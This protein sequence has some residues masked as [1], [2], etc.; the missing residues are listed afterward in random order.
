MALM[1][2]LSLSSDEEN[3]IADTSHDA[4][5]ARKL[6]CD[7]N[8]DIL[9]PP[10]DGKVIVLNDS[11]EEDEAQEEKTT[12]TEP[13]ATSIVVKSASTTSAD[14]DNAPTGAKNDNSD[15]QEPDQEA[16]GNDSGSG[17]DEP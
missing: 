9:E 2:D 6:F 12:G 14:T 1:I 3:F 16:G 11:N 13:V 15:D 10:S 8:C 5:F 7:L 4:E 17:T